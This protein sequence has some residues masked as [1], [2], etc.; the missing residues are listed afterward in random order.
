MTEGLSSK[1]ELGIGSVYR[2]L[3]RNSAYLASGTIASALFMMLAVVLAARAL[4]PREFGLLVLFQSA[5]Q[6][7]A[8]L[9]S[10]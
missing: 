7:V 4:S 9:T 3:A 6:M 10:F 5:T 8:T 1:R 2:R